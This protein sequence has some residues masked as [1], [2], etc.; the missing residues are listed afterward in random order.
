MKSNNSTLTPKETTCVTGVRRRP[1]SHMAIGQHNFA[2]RISD[3]LA[4]QF[5]A[6][7]RERGSNMTLIIKQLM[8][9]FIES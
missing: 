5:N 6:A 3:T 2:V 4:E 8:S 9:D 7:C 1:N